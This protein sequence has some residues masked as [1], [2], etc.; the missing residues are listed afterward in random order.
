MSFFKSLRFLPYLETLETLI[1][2][3]EAMSKSIQTIF[4]KIDSLNNKTPELDIL[5]TMIDRLEMLDQALLKLSKSESLPKVEPKNG[6]GAISEKNELARLRMLVQFL[7]LGAKV[8]QIEKEWQRIQQ[9]ENDSQFA[10]QVKG[11]PESEH[12]Y[13]KGIA[14]GVRWC[15]KHFSS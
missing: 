6:N 14:D 15:V 11:G 3:L 13:K 7:S 5:Q 2:R 9:D 1:P 4:T 10:V 8:D 12:F